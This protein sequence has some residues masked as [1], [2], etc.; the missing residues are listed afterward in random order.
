MSKH[1]LFIKK[2]KKF[3]LSTNDS[4]ENYFHKIKLLNSKKRNELIKNNKVFIIISILVIFTVSYFLIPTIYDKN[5]IKFQIKK[6]I[7]N[8]FDLKIEFNNKVTY[9]LLP[10]PHFKSKKSNIFES[11]IWQYD[12]QLLTGIVGS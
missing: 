12:L 5:S 3:F 4:I 2:I 1:N 10:R 7:E 11:E 6:Q 8:K 9:A